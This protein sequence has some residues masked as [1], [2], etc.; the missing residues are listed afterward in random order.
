MVEY[1][2]I[3]IFVSTLAE[4]KTI[5]KE[6]IFWNYKFIISSRVIDI[7]FDVKILSWHIVAWF[8]DSAHVIRHI[9]DGVVLEVVIDDLGKLFVKF[10]WEVEVRKLRG[11]SHLD[12]VEDVL[13]CNLEVLGVKIPSSFVYSTN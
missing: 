12:V 11:K 2:Y 5:Y 9:T 10:L 4:E 1:G 3:A 6:S 7:E 13:S 8:V